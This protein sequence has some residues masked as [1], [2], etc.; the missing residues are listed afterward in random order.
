MLAVSDNAAN[1]KTAIS[2]KLNWKHFGCLAHTINLIVKEGLENEF[3]AELIS[4]IKTIVTHFK[5]SNIAT[6]KLMTYQRNTGKTPLKLLQDV[7]TR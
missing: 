1:I 2:E 6:E 7:A 5:R 4:N 3:I